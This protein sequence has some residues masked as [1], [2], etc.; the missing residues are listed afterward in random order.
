MGLTVS[1][2]QHIKLN[3]ILIYGHSIGSLS[4]I[5]LFLCVSLCVSSCTAITLGVDSN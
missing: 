2:C 4:E 1:F 3:R 5:C